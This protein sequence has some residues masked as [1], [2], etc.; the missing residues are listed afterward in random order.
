MYRRISEGVDHLGIPKQKHRVQ[1]GNLVYL[2]CARGLPDHSS[3]PEGRH[4]MAGVLTAAR[5]SPHQSWPAHPTHVPGVGAGVCVARAG[6]CPAIPTIRSG[7]RRLR[8]SPAS[9]QGSRSCVDARVYQLKRT[10][11][12]SMKGGLAHRCRS[13]VSL[14]SHACANA[15]TREPSSPSCAASSSSRFSTSSRRLDWF[16]EVRH[17]SLTM[18]TAGRFVHAMSGRKRGRKQREFVVSSKATRFSGLVVLRG[19]EGGI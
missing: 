8:L 5:R 15:S 14:P 12:G 7:A 17:V 18:S 19:L 16:R 13:S 3:P 1:G 4:W 10:R 11:R 6:A 2:N 9:A